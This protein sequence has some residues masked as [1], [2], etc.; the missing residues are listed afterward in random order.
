MNKGDLMKLVYTEAE[1]RNVDSAIPI[2]L[3]NEID[4]SIY[5]MDYNN[6]G[7]FGKLVNLM[8]RLREQSAVIVQNRNMEEQLCGK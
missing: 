7:P 6:N 2:E 1:L 4:T 8:D 3:W 5:V